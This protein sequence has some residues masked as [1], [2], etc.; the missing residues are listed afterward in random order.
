MKLAD[1]KPW[2]VKL[3][4]Q[5]VVGVPHSE[6]KICKLMPSTVAREHSFRVNLYPKSIADC[7]K[8]ENF[9]IWLK[10]FLLTM[11]KFFSLLCNCSLVFVSLPSCILHRTKS[12]Q[13]LLSE[14]SRWPYSY[15]IQDQM[16]LKIDQGGNT[17]TCHFTEHSTCMH[18]S[19]YHN[20]DT[21]KEDS[22]VGDDFNDKM[23]VKKT[24][25]KLEWALNV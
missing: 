22:L 2:H 20:E 8:P 16:H 18:S 14:T 9:L 15:S 3:P 19:T 7:L 13:S 1:T 11:N 10:E 12:R 25:N 23:A 21:F 6:N 4:L 24:G 5:Q 17:A